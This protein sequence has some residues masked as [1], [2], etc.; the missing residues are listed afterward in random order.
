MPRPDRMTV[1]QLIPGLEVGGAERATVDIAS[2]LVAAGHRALVISAGGAMADELLSAGA[3]H[4]AW[5]IG[6]KNP[7]R[8]WQNRRRLAEFIKA[9]SVDIVHARSRAPAWS[10]YFA[11]RDAGVPFVTTFHDAYP[12]G[13]AVKHLYNSVMAKG[14]RVIAIS[15]FIEKHIATEYPEAAGRV[16]L[17]PRGVDFAVFDP[18]AI[19]P[20]RKNAFR[21]AHALPD[22][23]PLLILPA[24][25]SST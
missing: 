7:W 21:A 18:G 6:A 8:I 13:N 24:R 11:A 19:S 16:A 4:V 14:D 23:V 20:E 12:A 22:N 5:D 2:A 9:H 17:I 10:A 3:E 1:L 25:L 15:R